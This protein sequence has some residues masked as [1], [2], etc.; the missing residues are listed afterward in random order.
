MSMY[1][2]GRPTVYSPYSAKVGTKPPRKTPGEYRI[3]ASDGSIAYVGETCDLA[4]RIREH[5]RSGKINPTDRP[6]VA[7]KVA[8][9]RSSSRTRREHERQKISQHNPT[10]NCSG[11]GEGRIA[12]R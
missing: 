9:G 5:Q 2:P 3:F 1:K 11:G 4:R 12:G 7:F 6:T 8:D 10:L